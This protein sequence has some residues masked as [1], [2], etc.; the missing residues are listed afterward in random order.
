MK[1]CDDN[2]P[3][4]RARAPG[5]DADTA[6]PMAGH[7]RGKLNDRLKEYVVERLA[8]FDSPSA[9][10]KSLRDEFG[11]TIS[12]QSI[13]A[14]HALRRPRC[15]EKWKELFVA[16]RRA[17]IE[18]KAER[19]AANKMVRLRWREN[20]VLRAM[21]REDFALADRLLN[22]IAGEVGEGKCDES[23]ERPITEADRTRVLAALVAQAEA[24]QAHAAANRGDAANGDVAA[25]RTPDAEETA[26]FAERTP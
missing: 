4:A 26:A 16:T 15:A 12:R 10:A 14:Y 3:A 23:E 17:I 24:E 20:M 21:E 5:S 11:V 8:G 6:R 22:S 19:G 9:I 13:E 7:W 25:D 18:G 2:A 1:Q